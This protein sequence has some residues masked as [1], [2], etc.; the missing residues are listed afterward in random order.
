MVM[1]KKWMRGISMLLRS[2]I[3]FNAM[4]LRASCFLRAKMLQAN[5]K[6]LKYNSLPQSHVLPPTVRKMSVLL[7]D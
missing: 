6:A 3:A 4:R 2:S 7:Y 5:A 1:G